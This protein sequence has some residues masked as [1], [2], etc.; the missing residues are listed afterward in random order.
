VSAPAG[1]VLAAGEGR[2]FGRP[3][4]L[5]ELDGR[6]LVDRA[7]EVARAAGCDPVVVVLGAGAAEV[8]AATSLAG[9]V[10]VVNDDWR[11]GMGSSLRTGLS[12]L[13]DLRAA[14]AVILLVDQPVVSPALVRRLVERWRAGAVA[15]VASYDGEPRNPVVLDASTWPRVA[16]LATG[17]LGARGWLRTHPGDVTLVACD[18]LGRAVDIDR[19]DDLARLATDAA[20]EDRA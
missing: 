3:K 12:A 2:R 20:M 13:N 10:V 4:A 1:L 17:D 5:V 9:A 19:P 8:C 6:L 14:A 15:V 16:E 18:D 11:S 7:V